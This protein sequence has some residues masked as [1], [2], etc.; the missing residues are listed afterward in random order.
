MK[1]FMSRLSALSPSSKPFR[2]AFAFAAA[3]FR[4]CLLFAFASTRHRADEVAA[5]RGRRREAS[6]GAAPPII[7][8]SSS[9]R[10]AS[11]S[12][13]TRVCVRPV[14]DALRD[15]EMRV[16]GGGDLRQMRDAQHLKRLADA[17]AASSPPR[18]RRDRRCRRRSH[19]RSASCRA[20]RP[21]RAFGWPA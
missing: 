5:A 4:F 7:R 9:T 1:Y 10:S 15:L 8:A 19:R 2:A 13:T 14:R 3:R 17:R 21:R 18:R 20:R 12:R 16:P 11:F 6:V